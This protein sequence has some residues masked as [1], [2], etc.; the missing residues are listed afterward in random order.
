MGEVVCVD[1]GVV[2][3]VNDVVSVD[4]GVVEVVG[5]VVNDVVGVLR[6]HSAKVVSTSDEIAS[7]TSSILVPH[8]AS[9]MR[10][11]PKVQ[12][13][14][15]VTVPRVYLATIP[16]KMLATDRHSVASA[17][18]PPGVVQAPSTTHQ[19]PHTNSHSVKVC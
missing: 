4:V 8:S 3:V 6:W 18:E 13:I 16:F 19:T 10:A 7:L 15:L 17:S 11:L 9:M 1:V 2:E 12:A 5:D 14:L